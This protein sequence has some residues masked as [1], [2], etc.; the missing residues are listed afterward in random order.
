LILVGP[1]EKSI[2]TSRIL[3]EEE[4]TELDVL[5][6]LCEEASEVVLV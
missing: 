3:C 2:F 6:F 1:L 4:E 5:V